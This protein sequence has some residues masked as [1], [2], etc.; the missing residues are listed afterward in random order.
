MKKRVFKTFLLGT[1]A[2]SIF[3]VSCKQEIQTSVPQLFEE[4]PVTITWDTSK[5]DCID[6][7][8]ATVFVYEDSNR[9]TGGAKLQSQYKMAVK[10]VLDKQYVRLDFPA[11]EN[12][13]AKSVLSN[14]VD[15][16]LVDTETNSIERKIIT[17]EAELKLIDELGYITSQNTL[18]K[19]NLSEIR[20]EA[21]KLSLDMSE[22]KNEKVF[23][24][25]LPS[26]Y[27][28]ND[29]ETRLSTKVSYDKAHE[30]MET[31]ETVTQ[32]EDGSIVT[33]TTCPVY[34]EIEGDRIVKIGQYSI[35][36]TK[37]NVR[38]EG[39]EDIEYFDSLDSIP[40]ISNEDY[41]KLAEEGNATKIEEFPLGDPSDPS[42]VET[43]IELYEDIQINVVDDSVFKLIMEL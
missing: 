34:E 28:T 5:S 40:E 16:I 9:R 15:T 27:F 36:D 20:S 22:N 38:Y 11:T 8:S 12:I 43:L 42:S 7:F 35:I 21:A 30:L 2:T 3:V 13:A 19:I 32:K 31:V 41:E 6:T 1:I 4:N 10:T 14:G 39:L 24:V 33:V 18:S 23:T 25:E 26:R 29:K 17:P 37:S